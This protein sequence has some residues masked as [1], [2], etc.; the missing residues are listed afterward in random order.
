MALFPCI[1]LDLRHTEFLSIWQSI[2]KGQDEGFTVNQSVILWLGYCAG[3]QVIESSIQSLLNS[4]A[5]TE[6]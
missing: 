5:L 4:T 6:Q 2:I 1:L 3:K